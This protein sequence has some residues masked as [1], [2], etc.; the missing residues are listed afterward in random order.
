MSVQKQT[1]SSGGVTLSFPL[2]SSTQDRTPK[3]LSVLRNLARG[4]KA[5][6]SLTHSTSS[7]PKPALLHAMGLA[8]GEDLGTRPSR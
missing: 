7:Y 3:A 6:G 1:P 2:N 5:L 4:H 8:L